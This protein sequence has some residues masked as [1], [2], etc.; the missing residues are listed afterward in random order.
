MVSPTT[1]EDPPAIRFDGVSFSYG[2]LPALE[3]VSFA[4]AAGE[5]A[6]V[7]GPSAAGKTTLLRLV[8]GQLRPQR[9]G[10]RVDGQDLTRARGRALRRL[11]RRVGVIFQDYRLLGRLTA[12]ENVAYALRVVDLWLPRREAINRAGAA[13]EAVGLEDR[14][15]AFPRQLS[16]GQQ[17][18]LAIARALAAAPAILLADE[19]TASLDRVEARKILALFELAAKGGTAVL[20]ATHDAELVARLRY[21]VIGLSGGRIAWDRPLPRSA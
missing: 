4:V 6:Y 18:R 5:L 19:P 9:G 10:L 8:H 13:L 3:K 21:R 20:I 1:T 7:V 16:G 12:E 11:R 17:Q 14:A 15:R 2:R